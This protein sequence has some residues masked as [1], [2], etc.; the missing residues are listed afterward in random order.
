[1]TQNEWQELVID[2]Y[3][4]VFAIKKYLLT[5]EQKKQLNDLDYSI[6]NVLNGQTDDKD[7]DFILNLFN[8][9]NK[10]LGFKEFGF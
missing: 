8:S 9:W 7:K 6:E 3:F 4:L 2:G 10:T 1:M 5:P